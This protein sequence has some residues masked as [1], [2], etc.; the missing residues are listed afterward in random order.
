M[1]DEKL[2]KTIDYLSLGHKLFDIFENYT[3]VNK[4]HI[5]QTFKILV[6]ISMRNNKDLMSKLIN[7]TSIKYIY[8]FLNE[9]LKDINEFIRR[10]SI[11]SI[12]LL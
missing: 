8:D 5:Y 12:Y 6:N 7:L 10:E 1:N 9:L 3:F 2:Y 11:Y 4:I